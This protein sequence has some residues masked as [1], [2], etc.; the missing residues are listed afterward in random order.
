MQYKH[1]MLFF[2]KSFVAFLLLLN[3][4][5]MDTWF[6]NVFFMLN[7]FHLSFVACFFLNFGY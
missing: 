4:A 7:S 2:L 3:A 6:F 5:T 1:V